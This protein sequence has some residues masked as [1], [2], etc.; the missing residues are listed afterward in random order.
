MEVGIWLVLGLAA[1]PALGNFAGGLLA[2]W[3]RPSKHTLNLA[4]HASAGII[5]AV[6]AVEV[7][8]QA[9]PVAPA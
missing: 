5:L 2:D 6:I 7:M 1:L 8:P 3:L 4:L 9:L